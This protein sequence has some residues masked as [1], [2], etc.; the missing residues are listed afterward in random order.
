MRAIYNCPHCKEKVEIELT[1][2]GQLLLQLPSKE[3]EG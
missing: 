2:N 3:A 1:K